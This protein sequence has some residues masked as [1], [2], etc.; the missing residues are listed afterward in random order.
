MSIFKRIKYVHFH[1]D[2]DLPIIIRSWVTGSNTLQH[3]IVKPREKGILHSSVGEWHMDSMFDV[4][5]EEAKIWK[6][7]KL[8]KHH[9][10]GKFRSNPFISGEYSSMEHDEPFACTYSEIQGRDIKGTIVFTMK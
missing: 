5:T 10:I 6:E 4:D 7:R 8:E 2:T 1:N 9:I 3:Q